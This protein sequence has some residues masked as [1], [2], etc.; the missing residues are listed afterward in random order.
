MKPTWRLAKSLIQLRDQIN[1]ASPG[2]S[3]ASDGGIGNAEHASR[4][5][6]HNPWVKDAKGMGVV[7][8]FDFTVDIQNG[9]DGNV[10]AQSLTTDPR[11]KY[12]IFEGKIWKAQTGRW[13]I[14]RGVNPHR[15]HVHISVKPQSADDQSPWSL[16][17][18]PIK[19]LLKLGDKGQAVRVL[20]SKL[21]ITADGQFGYGTQ[22][23]VKAFQ[24]RNGLTVDGIC[25]PR[26]WG[27]L[28]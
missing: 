3:K 12:V 25:G 15:H 21:G 19:P 10:L 6:D 16:E 17:A 20:Q 22:K 26:C 18:E 23:A 24:E 5:S 4:A 13:E 28:G 14:Y 7:T 8:A 11:T 2:R 27:K 1:V 9:V